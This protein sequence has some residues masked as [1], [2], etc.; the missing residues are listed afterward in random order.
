MAFTLPDALAKGAPAPLGSS[1]V[2]THENTGGHVGGHGSEQGFAQIVRG[3]NFAVWSEHAQRIEVCIF[4]SSGARELRR[5]KLHGPDD[6]VFYG[7]LPGADAGLVYGLRAHGAYAPELGHRF[8][9]NK[10]LLDPY[11]REIV[12]TF[13][14][15]HWDDSQ[16]S[17]GTGEPSE[18]GGTHAFDTRDSAPFAL[19]ARVAAVAPPISWQRPVINAAEAILYEVHVKGFSMQLPGLPEHLR[20]SYAALAHP[21]AIQHFKRLGVTTLSLLPVQFCLSEAALTRQ[22][23]SNYWGYNTL[24]F[25]SPDP[26]FGTQPS[27]PSLLVR[28]FQAMVHDLHAA[29]IEVVLDVVFNHTA[30]GDAYG[31]SLSF[32][33]LD[34]RSWYLSVPDDLAACENFSGCGNT[35]NIA[36]PKVTRFVLDCLRYWVQEMGVDGFRFDLATVLGRRGSSKDFNPSA[37]FFIAL[38]QDPV[39]AKIRLISEPWDCGPNGYQLGRFPSRFIEWNDRFRDAMR[40][41]WMGLAV[42]RG[43]FARRFFASSDFFHHAHRKPLASVN[44]ISAHDGF[45]L[46]DALSYATKHNLAN[47]EQGQDGRND[48]LCNN[49][50]FEGNSNDPAINEIRLRVRHALLATLLLAQGTP[51]LLA[52]DELGNSQSGNNNAYSQDNQTAWL[53]WDLQQDATLELVSALTTLRKTYALL[54]YTDWFAADQQQTDHARVMWRAPDGR[55]M[56]VYDWHDASKRRLACELYAADDLQPSFCILFNPDALACRFA[57]CQ[58]GWQLAFDSSTELALGRVFD[59]SV[60]APARSLLVLQRACA[61]SS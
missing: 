61:D 16:S 28:E 40:R 7:E 47:G 54:R 2:F 59:A 37:A 45:T 24:G 38:Q 56:Q 12:G 30:E 13:H 8:N 55:E 42:T 39:L 17:Y 49:F 20:G 46:R 35:L 10:L 23:K 36:H 26:R 11:A 50:G 32:R 6:G 43:E 34:N 3:V 33:G 58:A 52:G 14:W 5:F 18:P 60:L 29:G 25:F 4:D 51:M 15:D 57:L 27:D 22:G 41:Y 44:F 21:L 19:K 9:S 31:P 1:L 53:D 48:E